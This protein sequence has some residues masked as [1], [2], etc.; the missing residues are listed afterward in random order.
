[1]DP[2]SQALEEAGAVG[3]LLGIGECGERAP[4]SPRFI[5]YANELIGLG[6]LRRTLALASRLSLSKCAPT[7]LILTGSPIEPTFRLP[8]RVDTVKLP[9]LSRDH[10]GQQYSARLELNR[11]E[12]RALRSGIALASAISFR[13]DVAVV[14]KLPLGHGGELEPALQQLKE[15]SSCRMV[16]GLRD[17]E[18]SPENVRRKW[19]PELRRAIGRYYDAIIVYGPES[20]L[21]AI[22]CLEQLELEVP[23]H[24]VGYVGTPIPDSG[25]ADLNGEYLL[26]TAG[27]GFDGFELLA[28]FAQAARLRP[29]PCRTLM[30]A[31]PLMPDA[32]RARLDELTTGLD[33][34]VCELRTDME[35]VIAG[36]R[37]VISMAGYN[38]VSE[39]MRARKPALL[40][41]RIGP[42]QEQLI[43]A[44]ELSAMG[45]QDMLHPAD[46]TPAS[47]RQSL[48][49]LLERVAPQHL[50]PH[51]GGTE[52]AAEIL[53]AL[54]RQAIVGP[55][56]KLH[57]VEAKHP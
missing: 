54:A 38:T 56:G 8:P 4:R 37:A 57:A 13:P 27:G 45:L 6:Q 3:A 14:D 30:V 44:R 42:S 29:L 52:R 46:L 35:H 49:R 33:I 12:L 53:V 40:V 11:D 47:L 19:G 50:P 39:L 32:Q 1:M 51:Y 9:G 28:T 41:P 34:Q 23:V 24:H 36:A 31:G 55:A 25:P 7:S 48:D 18:D 20:S 21:D 10:R 26:V 16:L 2:A 15:T 17:I 43:R 5:F 22:D